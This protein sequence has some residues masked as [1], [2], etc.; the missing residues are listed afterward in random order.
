MGTGAPPERPQRTCVA[1]ERGEGRPPAGVA[2]RPPLSPR[3]PPRGPRRRPY[4]PR[5]APP[6]PRAPARAGEAAAARAAGQAL[7]LRCAPR[8]AFPGRAVNLCGSLGWRSLRACFFFSS[9]GRCGS[10]EGKRSARVEGTY[11]ENRTRAPPG[12]SG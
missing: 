7:A 2:P 9:R 5:S 4:P 6:S 10:V 3:P 12:S 1:G 8:A 11:L